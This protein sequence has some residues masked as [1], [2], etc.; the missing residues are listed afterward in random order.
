MSAMPSAVRKRF[1]ADLSRAAEAVGAQRHGDAWT[2]L[3]EAH[4]LSQPW[5][6]AH[7]RVHWRMLTVALRAR[8]RTE[9]SGQILR[10]AVA[11]PGSL[12]GRY[13]AGNTGRANVGLTQAM[14]LAPDLATLLESTAD[15]TDHD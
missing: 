13:P 14:A 5:A 8:D 1:D 9:A 6:V 3:E 15:R 11:A 2:A 12:L 4:V 7:V 10:L